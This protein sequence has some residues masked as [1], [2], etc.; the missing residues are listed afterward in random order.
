M[1]CQL[2]QKLNESIEKAYNGRKLWLDIF[3]KYKLSDRDYVIL[4]PSLNSEYN[5]Y[6]LLHLDEFVRKVKAEKIIILTYDDRV[7]STGKLFTNRIHDICY[8][9]RENMEL[10]MKFYC[11]YMFTDK[12][13]IVSL[14]E[15]EGRS[16]KQL[17][18]KKGITLEE[19]IAIG[20]YGLEKCEKI[21]QPYY[22][23]NDENIKS[24]LSLEY[25]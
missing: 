4:M 2:K 18:G 21:T 5:Y 15:P 19:I 12:L 8:F 22:D 20:I 10:L 25:E 16:G 1:T 17:I 23:G 24:F 3:E 7:Q 14:E 9:S 6:A 11:L 13:I